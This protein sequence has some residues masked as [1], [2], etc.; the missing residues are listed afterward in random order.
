MALSDH[1]R[2]LK[3]GKWK[4]VL[5]FGGKAFCTVTTENYVVQITGGSILIT[6]KDTNHV[7]LH[8]KGYHYLYTGDVSPDETQLCVLENG[9]HFYIITLSDFLPVQRIT[10]PR[11][12][13]AID[14]YPTYS[15]DGTALYVPVQ[16]YADGDYRYQLCEYETESYSLEKKKKMR[17]SDV[18]HW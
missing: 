5:A 8:R 15:A 7:V 11:S 3:T 6:L 12:Y 14:V 9:K 1:T 13:E 10:L 18:D 17:K 16:K 4:R 2:I